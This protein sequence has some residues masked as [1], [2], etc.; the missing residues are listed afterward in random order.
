L[1]ATTYKGDR[2]E[3]MIAADLIKHGF[4][5]CKPITSDARFDLIPYKDREYY[6]VQCKHN[7]SHGET[8][9]IKRRRTGQSHMTKHT[10]E[11]V[12][13]IAN[14]DNTSGLIHYI[15]ANKLGPEG[16][17]Q[18]DLRLVPCKK[19]QRSSTH[20]SADFLEPPA[21]FQEPNERQSG[22]E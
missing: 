12:D 1:G 17:N 15:G 14:F 7:T 21:H 16:R 9:V 4:I 13:W 5:I 19:H 11:T 22:P 10:P 3:L 8:I 18:F 20:M 6:R 2:A